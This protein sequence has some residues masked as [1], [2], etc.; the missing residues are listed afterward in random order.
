MIRGKGSNLE[1]E[2]S[3]NFETCQA[4]DEVGEE[5]FVDK[6]G[7]HTNRRLDYY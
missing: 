1:I 5:D 7:H 6:K 2:D 3:L 4:N